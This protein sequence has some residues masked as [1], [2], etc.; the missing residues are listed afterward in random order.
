VN[1]RTTNDQAR[2]ALS[3]ATLL[4]REIDA[5]LAALELG[6]AG[7]PESTPGAAPPEAQPAVPCRDPDC[8]HVRPCPVHDEAPVALTGPERGAE[9]RDP[10]RA[11]LDRLV[12]H[13]R[14]VAH[15]AAAAVAITHRYAYAGVN[16]GTV[17]AQLAA[18]DAG[19]WCEHCVRFGEHNPREEGRKLCEFCRTFQRDWKHLPSRDIWQAR[20]ARGGRLDVGTIE[21]LLRRAKLE[22]AAEQDRERETKRA[23]R[24]T[25]R[26]EPIAVGDA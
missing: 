21:R 17:T 26:A 7:W 8:T 4:V 24:Q 3:S 20:N 5:A 19:I 11:D 14:L 1:P 18:I 16:E 9:H 23:A 6:L 15:H 10:A 22:R 13:V 25:K 12:E 2:A